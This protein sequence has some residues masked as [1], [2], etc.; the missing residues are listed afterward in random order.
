[1]TLNFCKGGEEN[2]LPTLIKKFEDDKGVALSDQPLEFL[3]VFENPQCAYGI[4]LLR[5]IK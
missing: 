3:F 4:E 2:A 5:T 1:M